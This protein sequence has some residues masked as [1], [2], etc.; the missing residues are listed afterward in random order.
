MLLSKIGLPSTKPGNKHCLWES[1]RVGALRLGVG[2]NLLFVYRFRLI[3]PAKPIPVQ[4][5]LLVKTSVIN[6]TKPPFDMPRQT[7]HHRDCERRCSHRRHL[8]HLAL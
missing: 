2:E 5:A 4:A 1:P 8:T 6:Y 7:S 3:R